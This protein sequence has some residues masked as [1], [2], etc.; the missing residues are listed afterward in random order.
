MTIHEIRENLLQEADRFK[1]IGATGVFM[2]GSRARQDNRTDSDLDLFIEYGDRNKIPSYFDLLE[3]QL[4]IEDRL[5]M[6]VHLGTRASLDP[7]IRKE[8]EHD[9]IRIF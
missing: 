1:S 6:A 4:R 2:F 9:A 7:S 8:V 3:V 5:G